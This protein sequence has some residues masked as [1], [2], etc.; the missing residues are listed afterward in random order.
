MPCSRPV[1]QVLTQ[2]VKSLVFTSRAGSKWV[3]ISQL[4]VN[5]KDKK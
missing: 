5:I 3:Q 2:R 4:L 1:F